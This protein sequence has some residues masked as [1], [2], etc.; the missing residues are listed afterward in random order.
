MSSPRLFSL[1]SKGEFEPFKLLIGAITSLLILTI[2]IST[3]NYF[4]SLEI[5]ISTERF[6]SGMKNAVNQPNG[7]LLVAENVVFAEGRAISS[8]ELAQQA[9]LEDR[10]I[11]MQAGNSTVFTVAPSGMNVRVLERVQTE[12]Y[13]QCFSNTLPD[14][15]NADECQVSCK[16]SLGAKPV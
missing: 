6:Y 12:V 16:V 5:D 8:R 9:G 4:Q 11:E 14:A 1:N 2:I 10:C 13:I 7:S 3:I 15:P